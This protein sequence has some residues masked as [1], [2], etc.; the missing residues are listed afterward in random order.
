VLLTANYIDP[1]AANTACAT[2]PALVG[3]S[4]HLLTF[5]STSKTFDTVANPYNIQSI[6]MSLIGTTQRFWVGANQTTP[7][8]GTGSSAGK[9]LVAA[10]GRAMAVCCTLHP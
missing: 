5:A 4:A 2:D 8:P 3:Y 7:A 9:W 10:A 6:A 1:F